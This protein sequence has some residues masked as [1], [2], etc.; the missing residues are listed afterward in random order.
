VPTRDAADASATQGFIAR[1]NGHPPQDPL[2]AAAIEPTGRDREASARRRAAVEI[3]KRYDLADV[4]TG[5]TSGCV[6][7]PHLGILEPEPDLAQ[8]AA[9]DRQ[10]EFERS[11]READERNRYVR[12]AAARL[13]ERRRARWPGSPR[14]S[15]RPVQRADDAERR[16][17]E[18][19]C[20]EIG[21]RPVSYR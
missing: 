14:A 3:L 1:M 6:F 15:S 2:A 20:D 16:R 21:Q 9:L 19:A 5:S 7:D 4:I 11:Q 10:Y 17:Y 13:E 12:A 18:Q 8:R